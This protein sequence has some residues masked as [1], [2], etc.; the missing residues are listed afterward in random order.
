MKYARVEVRDKKGIY[1]AVAESLKTDIRD[2]GI[3]GVKDAEY[4]QVYTFRGDFTKIEINRVA[5]EILTDKISQ[6]FHSEGG[7]HK[8]SARNRHVVEIAYNPG[9]MDPVEESVRK[10]IKD[11]GL[12]GITSVSTSKKYVIKGNISSSQVEKL[13]DKLLYNKIIQHVVTHEEKEKE[14]KPYNFEHVEIDL[15]G[16]SDAKL[17]KL[18]REGQ[19]YLNLPEMKA[20]KSHFKKLKR[21]PTDCELETLAQTWSEHCKHKTMMGAISFNGKKFKNL[22]KETVMKVTKELK[23]SWCVS[24][25][26]DNAGIIKFDAKHNICFKVETHNHPSALE[27]YGGAETG[28]GGV[29]RDPMGTG[30]GSKPI[31]NTDIFC[32]GMPNMPQSKVPKG[33]LHPKRV[34]KGVVSG[35]R[36]YG[37]KMGIP[38]VNGSVCFDERY[39]GNPLVFCGNVGIMPKK[40][41]TKKVSPGDLIVAV[42][43]RTGRD[44]IHGAT[45][46]SAELT[47]E[48]ETISSTAVQIGNPITEKKMLDTLIKARDLGLYDAITDC[49]AGGFSSAVGEMGE[50]TGAEVHIEKAPLKY[51]G[52]KPWEIWVSEAQ[53]RMVLAV[54]PKNLKRL[55]NIF[56]SEDVEANVIGKF[57]KTKK[58]RIFYK[59]HMVSDLDMSFLHDGLPKVTR[60]AVWKPRKQDKKALP[61]KKKD[62]TRDLLKTLSTWNVCS[63]EWIIRQYDHEV[64]GGSVLKPLIGVDNDSPADASITRP[65]LGSNRGIALS[66]GINPSYG[67]IDPYWMAASAIDEALRQITAVGGDVRKVA[68]LDNFCWG[69]TE[70]PEQLGGLVRA[71]QACYDMAKVYG[72]P[73][74]S[75]KDSLNNEFNLGKKT[76]SIPPTLLISAIGVI[77][78]VRKTLSSDIKERDNLIYAIGKTF[79]EMGGSQYFLANGKKGGVIPRVDPVKSLK[80]M[81]KL[82]SAIQKDLVRSAHDCSEG[83]IGVALSEML[84]AGG[85]GAEVSLS[86]VPKERSITRD[87]VILFSESN[88]RFIVEV[89]PEKRKKFEK[90]MKGIPVGLLGKVTGNTKLVIKG[91]K[92]DKIVK[93]DIHTLKDSWKSPFERLM[94]EKS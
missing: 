58:L 1:D 35:V 15:I 10:A 31:I 49:G 36:D 61:G 65:L 48:S 77:D 21:N 79:Q 63:K 52:L 13:T 32:F 88:S 47:T 23:K 19:L 59:G 37:N 66:N 72:T 8:E 60:K 82:F 55:M 85:L 25:F 4:V 62:L 14:L 86:K 20:I 7:F 22:L 71:S 29:I 69:N 50:E 12:K 46:S 68:I 76:V 34:L 74:I 45:F 53:E 44:G 6:E 16:A 81:K 18:S 30:R 41:S 27:P 57:T 83:G 3:T 93:T 26:K 40:F 2:L 94:H 80:A 70:K 92:G 64:Q 51:G 33:A 38:T 5:D 75:G 67:D 24:V 54:K 73:F 89:T 56:K 87:D 84:F 43:G 90:A 91:V 28:I 78:D 11:M 17:K 9:V 42:G 39:T